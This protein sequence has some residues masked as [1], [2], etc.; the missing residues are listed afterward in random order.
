MV[1]LPLSEAAEQTE[2]RSRFCQGF[3][4]CRETKGD[5]TSTQ[6]FLYLYSTEERGSYSRLTLIPF[7][8]REINPA[9][10]YLRRSVL[11]PLGISERKGDASYF[12]ILPVY[13]HEIGRAHV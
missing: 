8:S 5:S 10:G 1:P 6:A 12:Q 3:L 9:V 4:Y 7:Y 11:W 13:W 2:E